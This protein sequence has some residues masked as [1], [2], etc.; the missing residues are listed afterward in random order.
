MRN[1]GRVMGREWYRRGREKG[2]EG[3]KGRLSEWK[4]YVRG[5]E[6][7][8]KGEEEGRMLH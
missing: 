8:G 7:N 1:R 6:G 5:M 2:E 3:R 4:G